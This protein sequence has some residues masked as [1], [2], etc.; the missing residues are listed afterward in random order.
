[1]NRPRLGIGL[2]RSLHVHQSS[3]YSTALRVFPLNSLSDRRISGETAQEFVHF[4]L[5]D[6]SHLEP[7]SW[8]MPE[9][10]DA[11]AQQFKEWAT[12]PLYPLL[13]EMLYKTGKLKDG[14][15]VPSEQAHDR[16][17]TYQDLSAW[18]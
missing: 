16:A 13:K 2:G 6:T 12:P 18:D 5:I 1:M 3:R 15:A 7:Y 14:E 10:G 8:P 11:A 4:G 9:V 17:E